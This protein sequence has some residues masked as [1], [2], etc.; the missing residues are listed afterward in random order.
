MRRRTSKRLE[1]NKISKEIADLIENKRIA[2][3]NFE[4]AKEETTKENTKLDELRKLTRIEAETKAKLVNEITEI[5]KEINIIRKE[6]EETV[7]KI[8]ERSYILREVEVELSK[9]LKNLTETDLGVEIKIQKLNDL[10]CELKS[11]KTQ[12][13]ST[14]SEK[15]K[16]ERE[17]AK[18]SSEIELKAKQSEKEQVELRDRKKALD[19]MVIRTNQR[20]HNLNKLA[21]NLNELSKT[22]SKSEQSTTK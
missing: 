7:K 5:R 9:L 12:K 16:I 2:I 20:G 4:K 3:I 18:I 13:N 14:Q 8:A 10:Q 19:I 6:K 1:Q 15:M 22:L 21:K 17:I 11:L